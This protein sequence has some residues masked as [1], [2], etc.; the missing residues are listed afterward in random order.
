MPLISGVSG[1]FCASRTPLTS[2]MTKSGALPPAHLQSLPLLHQQGCVCLATSPELFRHKIIRV[3][4]M[5][6]SIVSQRTGIDGEVDPEGRGYA[7]LNS[8]SQ[9]HYLNSAWHMQCAGPIQAA[10]I[11]V[12]LQPEPRTSTGKIRFRVR[13]EG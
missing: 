2:P 12:I 10:F 7:P 4:C 13:F 9:S 6:P 8:T 3:L 11:Y 5:Q 1:A